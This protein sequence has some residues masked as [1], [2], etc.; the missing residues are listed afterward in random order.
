MVQRIV[1]TTA[2]MRPIAHFSHAARVGDV[3]YV[4][5]TAGTNA[6]R[7]LAGS[8]VGLVD[9]SAQTRQMFDN[10]ALAL[11]L[12]GGSWQDLVQVKTYLVDMRDIAA[13]RAIAH[14]RFRTSP[15]AHAVAGAWYFPLPQAVVE[16]DAIAIVGSARKRLQTAT[17]PPLA[18]H[19]PNG[20]LL[21][22]GHHFATLL[23]F[24]ADG[25]IAA[26]DPERQA[27]QIVSNLET[28][29]KTADLGARELIRLHITVSDPRFIA[30]LDRVMARR[31]TAPY[32][33]RT[34]VAAQLE[35]A[36]AIFQI[37]SL[38]ISGGGTP[39]GGALGEA[40]PAS[41]AML[42]GDTLYTSGLSAPSSADPLAQAN[43]AFD[44]L[45]AIMAEAGL[46][47]SGILRTNNVLSHWHH[48]PAFNQAYGPQV[49]WPYPPRTTVL[50][51]LGDA[52]A[53]VQIEA[54]AHRHGADATILQVPKDR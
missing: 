22:N 21:A 25:A 37:E 36:C 42:V 54:I 24:D 38:A 30:A 53:H 13:Y 11:E 4:G 45:G 7:E 48:F 44:R 52:L 18:S 49:T 29:L 26:G 41:A 2:L 5:A 15:P 28:A 43:S 23:P 6:E 35:D 40:Q 31:L 20:G 34:V 27:E 46:P 33:A 17:L 12:L 3:I 32:P 1:E 8:R 39:V 47:G 19:G 50:G 14:E 16:L 9:A 51:T 10:L